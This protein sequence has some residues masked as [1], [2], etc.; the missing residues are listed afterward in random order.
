[1]KANNCGGQND[2][3]GPLKGIPVSLKWR[4]AETPEKFLLPFSKLCIP[5]GVEEVSLSS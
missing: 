1:M 4:L 2:W 5:S 3:A